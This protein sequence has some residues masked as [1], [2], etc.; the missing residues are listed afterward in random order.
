M[1][2]DTSYL[3]PLAGMAVEGIP[4]DIIGATRHAGYETWIC[5]VSLFELLAKGAKFAAAG[6]VDE[7]RLNIAVQAVL[8]DER[9]RKAGA[10][11]AEVGRTS[12]RLR[13]FH[14][15]FVDCLIIASALEHCEGLVSEEDFRREPGLARFIEEKKPGFR[16]LA[17]KDV[18]PIARR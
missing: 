8:S 5:D 18:V 1:L 17:A 6:K 12:V 16:L 10:Y 15:D 2:V 13:R 9:I 11:E 3:L 7:E 14:R 4:D